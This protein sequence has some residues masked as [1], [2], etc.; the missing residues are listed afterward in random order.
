MLVLTV[1]FAVAYVLASWMYRDNEYVDALGI[2][3]FPAAM[4]LTMPLTYLK[5][6]SWTSQVVIIGGCLAFLMLC[7]IL[8]AR[9]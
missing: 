3:S 6:H 2:I 7:S 1:V 5:G 4:L 9:M 8:A